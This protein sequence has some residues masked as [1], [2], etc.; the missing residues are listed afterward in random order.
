MKMT[1]TKIVGYIL[2]AGSPF[3]ITLS[4]DCMAVSL[5]LLL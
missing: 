5:F 2:K 4:Y 3:Y 1:R